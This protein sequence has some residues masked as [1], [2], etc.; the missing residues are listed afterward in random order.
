VRATTRDDPQGLTRRERE[1][2]D[3]VEQGLTNEQIGRR[4]VISSKTVDHH[5]SSVL[6]KLGVSSRREAA[7][8]ASSALTR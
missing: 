4:L 1:V 5:V 2:L 6:A 7:A 8:A 3:L